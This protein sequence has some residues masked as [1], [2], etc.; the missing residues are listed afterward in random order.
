M[1]RLYLA[2]G[3]F[4]RRLLP[5]RLR[6]A[7]RHPDYLPQAETEPETFPDAPHMSLH[8]IHCEDGTRFLVARRR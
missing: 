5:K 4:L 3:V 2:L 8:S 7:N 6:L 1:H